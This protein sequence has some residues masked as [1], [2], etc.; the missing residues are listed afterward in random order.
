[1]S[2]NL[3]DVRLAAAGLIARLAHKGQMD[4]NGEPYIGHPKAVASYVGTKEEKTVALLHD[5]VE[6]TDVTEE[7]L[8]P[9]FG[10]RIT[11][12]VM[13]LT[14]EEGVPYLDYV[15]NLKD[16]PLAKTVKLADLKHNMDL[17]RCKGEVPQDMYER[18]EKKYKPAYRILTQ[19]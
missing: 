17:S 11:D 12:A 14:H 4:R 13:L 2:E 15:R 10:K 1:M 16:N 8:R 7:E 6:D 18:M 3:E 19:D 9:I 5:V